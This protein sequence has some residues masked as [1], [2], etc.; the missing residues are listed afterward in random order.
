MPPTT[1]LDELGS[2]LQTAVKQQD[3]EEVRRL[4]SQLGDPLDRSEYKAVHPALLVALEEGYVDT[5]DL[6]LTRR[7][8]FVNS[9]PVD[10]AAVSG[11]H[12]PI[13]ECLVKHGWNVNGDLDYLG[14]LLQHAIDVQGEY[15]PDVC[16]WLIDHGA[17]INKRH[18]F[19]GLN[20]LERACIESD[21]ELIRYLLKKGATGKGNK[22]LC[23][24]AWAGHIEAL[25]I[26]LSEDGGGMDVNMDSDPSDKD[27][28]NESSGTALHNAAA[29]G[30]VDS[31]KF[32]LS[33]GARKDIRNGAGMTPKDV[34][35]FFEH[36]EC[37]KALEED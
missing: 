12:T 23:T 19:L 16:R 32:L 34:A 21:P 26:L 15:N 3:T 36:P 29:Y 1:S 17:D 18:A 30:K 9:V 37:V 24:A 33:K 35:I 14:T 28:L 10:E 5:A 8:S 13:L 22:P 20:P 7:P 2:A 25:R 4:L 11:A 6:M 31:I 27:Y